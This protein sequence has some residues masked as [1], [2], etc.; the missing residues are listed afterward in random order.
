[1]SRMWTLVALFVVML[2]IAP[3]TIAQQPIQYIYDD[4]G[5][6]VGVVDPAA[7][8]APMP[9][10]GSSSRTCTLVIRRW[11]SKAR[12]RIALDGRTRT[13]PSG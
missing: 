11:T 9:P 3:P 8:T 2:A 7:D 4:L 6:L 10:V 1:M 13:F 5:R 12:P